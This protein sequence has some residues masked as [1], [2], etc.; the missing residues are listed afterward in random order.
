[1]KAESPMKITIIFDDGCKPLRREH[2]SPEKQNRSHLVELDD[3]YRPEDH[4]HGFM[5]S[6]YVKPSS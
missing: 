1:M 2:A 5:I 3:V 4:H 6:T